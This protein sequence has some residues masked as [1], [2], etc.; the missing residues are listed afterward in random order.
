MPAD[1]SPEAQADAHVCLL[2]ALG[3]PRA[4]IAGGS[5]GAPSALQAVIRHPERITS[6]IL[7]VPITYR[8]ATQVDAAPPPDLASPPSI[9]SSPIPYA[10]TRLSE[11]AT[12]SLHHYGV[13][14]SVL[15]P[16]LIV[17]HFTDTSTWTSAFNL[18]SA[19]TSNR[20]ELPGTCSH[21][22]VEQDGTIHALVGEDVRCRHAVGMNHVALGI[23]MVESSQGKG[24]AFGDGEILARAAQIDAVLHLVKWLQ[25]K[26]GIA[27][28]HV[29]GHAMANASPLFLDL[30]GWTNDHVDWL[31]PDVIELRKRLDALP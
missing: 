27:T 12:Y 8:P 21:Y 5:A 6:L 3:I 7:L 13:A 22:I 18:F 14:T 28:D 24:G 2:D 17:L 25:L 23:E 16:Q 20:G 29:I 9:V 31:E 19:D 11:M 30:E 15:V 10:A 1:S 4:A 26:Y